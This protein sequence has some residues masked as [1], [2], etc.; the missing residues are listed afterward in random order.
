MGRMTGTDKEAG[1]P[2]AVEGGTFYLVGTPLG[3]R[4][5]LS[6]RALAVLTGVDVLLAEDTRVIARL[7]AVWGVERG[8]VWSFHAHNWRRR[9]PEVLDRLQSGAS[10]GLSTDAGMPGVSDP[11]RELVEAV[12]ERGLKLAV[13]PGPTAESAAFA[14]SG[15]PHPYRFWGFLPAKGPG[16]RQALERLAAGTETEVLYEAPHRLARTAREL[17]ALV[18]AQVPV[19]VGRELTKR[20]E[21]HWRGTLGELA[22]REEWRGEL[23]VV[24]GPRLPSASALPP[25][26]WTELLAAVAAEE[27]RGLSRRDSIRA[28]ADRTGVSRRELYR[29][30]QAD[31]PSP[32]A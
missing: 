32:P 9:L 10:V 21:E 7:L 19:Y 13:V 2:S 23:V 28:V 3:N 11:G 26:G 20:H 1:G 22:A 24:I 14:L 16:R 8:A 17:A 30:V 31:R 15:F 27:A 29:R 4:W 6:P 5:D 12:T 25:A 18:G